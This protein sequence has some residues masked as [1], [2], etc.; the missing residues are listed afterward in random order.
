MRFL[1]YFLH[2]RGSWHILVAD[3][4]DDIFCHLT[5]IC[6]KGT[7]IIRHALVYFQGSLKMGITVGYQE[8]LP[9]SLKAAHAAIRSTLY[10]K[11]DP[12]IIVT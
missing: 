4:S 6:L 10:T 2:L 12:E 5:L 11:V 7:D 8:A 3:R 1:R 9:V